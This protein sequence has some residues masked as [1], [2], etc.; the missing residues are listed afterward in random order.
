MDNYRELK[1]RCVFVFSHLLYSTHHRAYA[2]PSWCTLL[3]IANAAYTFV[4]PHN[5]PHVY[6]GL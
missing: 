6:H 3:L 2:E 1:I 5:H 4:N